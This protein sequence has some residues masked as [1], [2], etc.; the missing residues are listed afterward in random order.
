MNGRVVDATWK[1][2]PIGYFISTRP[3]N[4][5]S[6]TDLAGAV[7]RA[8]STWSLVESANVRFEFQGLTSAP[9]ESFDRSMIG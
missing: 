8:T 3:G 4:G 5:V 6:V 1:R 9:A 2:L 7:E